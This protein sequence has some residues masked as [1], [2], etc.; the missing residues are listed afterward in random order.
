M[1]TSEAPPLSATLY[2]EYEDGTNA[3]FASSPAW[4][5]AI[6]PAG[7]WRSTGYD[8]TQ[9]K[10]AAAWAAAPG[11]NP[12]PLGHP[13]IPDSVKTLRHTFSVD[14]KIK[15]ARLYSTALGA[16]EMFINGKRV[17]DDL[18][19]RPAGPTIASV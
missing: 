5:T 8:D 19:W 2:V 18:Y 13:W 12:E 7:D 9:W 17:S 14:K 11:P 10:N 1:A 6:H 3:T 16:Y 15:S 4:K